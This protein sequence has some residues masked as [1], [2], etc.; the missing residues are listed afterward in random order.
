MREGS[1]LD[2]LPE[3][4]SARLLAIYARLLS[5]EGLNRVALAGESGVA[6]RSIQRDIGSLRCFLAEQRLP[7]DV[8]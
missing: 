8:V 7:Q 1:A 2:Y 5:G 3:A 6:V 4:K